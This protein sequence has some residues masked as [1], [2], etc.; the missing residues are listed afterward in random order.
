MSRLIILA[1]ASEIR[2]RLLRN[3]GV[4]FESR[5]ARI[6]EAMIRDSLLAEGAQPRDIADALAEFKAQK[7]ATSENDAL[8]IGCD[9]VLEFQGRILSKPE[10]I[11]QARDQLE[12]L[13]GKEHQLL[14]AVVVFDAAKPVWRHIGKVHLTMRNFSDEYLE[15]YLT[16]NWE[17]IRHSVGGY[18]LEEEGVRLFSGITGDYFTVLGLPLL[19]LLSYLSEREILQT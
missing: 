4:C 2:Q 5:T 13:R 16:R 7:L 10:N 11:D 14:S 18:K 6:D 12:T 3:A 8:V 9:Q 19:E 17:R 15:S 1:S